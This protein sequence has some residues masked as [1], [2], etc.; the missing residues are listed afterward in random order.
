MHVYFLS[1]AS[2]V[3]RC[4]DTDDCQERASILQKQSAGISRWSGS[5]V[6]GE[7][8]SLLAYDSAG[9]ESFLER[10]LIRSQDIRAIVIILIPKQEVTNLS[11]CPE[12]L[13]GHPFIRVANP[14]SQY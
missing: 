13:K 3:C 11:T 4:R 12:F 1:E 7:I 5:S 14:S 8:Q 10:N 9:T 6:H 2:S